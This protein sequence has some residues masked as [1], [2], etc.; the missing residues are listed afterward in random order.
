M[1]KFIL[2]VVLVTALAALLAGTALAAGPTT[3]PVQ[4]FGPGNGMHTPGTGLT[5]PGTGYGPGM[6]MGAGGMMGRGVP[7]WA[8]E[9]EAVEAL[10]GMTDEQI[11]AD[12]LAGKSLAQIAASKNVSEDKL[13]STMVEAKKVDLAKLVAAG[14]LTQT[15][16]DTMVKNMQTQITTMVERT[17]VGPAFAQ[18]QARPGGMTGQSFRGGRGANR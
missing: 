3:P 17:N 5:T 16:M 6:G 10:L 4:G 8:G 11:H 2:I 15:Q 1:K 14:K 9:P 18:G 12:R 13:I 7:A